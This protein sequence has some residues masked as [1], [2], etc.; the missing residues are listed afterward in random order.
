MRSEQFAFHDFGEAKNGVEAIRKAKKLQPDLVLVDLTMKMPSGT[1]T[2]TALQ[3]L[4]P[5]PKIILFT[6][7]AKGGFVY[8][9]PEFA[10]AVSFCHALVSRSSREKLIPLISPVIR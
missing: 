9:A 3:L 5:R 2:A 4:K 6:L 7:H 1:D 10:S 8:F